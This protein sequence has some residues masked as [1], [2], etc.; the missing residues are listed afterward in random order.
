VYYVVTFL[1]YGVGLLLMTLAFMGLWAVAVRPMFPVTM[2]AVMALMYVAFGG[3]GFLLSAA[4]R[5]DWLSLV[6]VLFVSNVL[7][8]TFGDSENPLRYLLYLLPPA[9]RASDVHALMG[10]TPADWAGI[11]WISG[12]GL[13]C[14][15]LGMLVIR[16]RPLGTS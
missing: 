16:K 3:I 1:V 9:H 10:Q 14:F 4:W 7:W 6:A 11:L 12:Y 15:L 13:A 2:L 5:F 8:A